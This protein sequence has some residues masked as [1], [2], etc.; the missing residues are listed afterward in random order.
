MEPKFVTGFLTPR[1]VVRGENQESYGV[2]FGAR[3]F[4]DGSFALLGENGVTLYDRSGHKADDFLDDVFVFKNGFVLKKKRKGQNW[5][6]ETPQGT[7]IATADKAEIAGSSWLAL[8]VQGQ[9]WNVYQVLGLCF[10]R[11]I[12]VSLF[13]RRWQ[14]FAKVCTED[15]KIYQGSGTGS[16]VFAL[17]DGDM[18]VLQHRGAVFGNITAEL[19][20]R[21]RYL[22]LPNGGFVLS[23]AAFRPVWHKS[24]C[25]WV[26]RLSGGEIDLYDERLQLCDEGLSD[27]IM[28]KNGM[29]FRQF[30]TEWKLVAAD[31]TIL[32][33]NVFDLQLY[34]TEQDVPCILFGSSERNEHIIVRFFENGWLHF[35]RS[36]IGSFLTPE[37]NRIE[38][39]NGTCVP[40]V[41]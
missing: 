3:R 17:S 21:G 30:G 40:F 24:G 34:E 22:Y 27:I 15:L 25:L 38:A 33:T 32:E 26:K 13:P 29:S 31:G 23:D 1:V 28:F 14:V 8:R 19:T 37:G 10:E 5:T 36:G 7:V 2:C 39:P 4:D 6:F 12:S 11:Q 16:L 35:S 9:E 18:S 41:V 20:R